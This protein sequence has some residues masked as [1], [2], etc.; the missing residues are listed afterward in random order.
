MTDD[1]FRTPGKD[2]AIF[3]GLACGL[4]W[5]LDIPMARAL[6]NGARPS[7]ATMAMA[8][9]SA[10]GPTLAA[11]LVAGFRKELRSVFG[12][13]RTHPR[14]IVLSLLLL[15]ALHLVATLTELALGGSPAQWFYPPEKAEHVLA[16]VFF[17]VGEEFGWRGFAHPRLAQR[18]GVVP[19]SVIIGLVWTA[20][21]YVMWFTPAGAPSAADLAQGVV[22]LVAG[23]LIYAWVFER[24]GR[25]MAVAIAL[26][27]SAHLDNTFRAPDSEFR[28]RMLRLVVLSAVAGLATWSLLKRDR[29]RA[30]PAPM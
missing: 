22:Q 26:H 12:H 17:S 9:L 27:M 7:E 1:T 29:A 5:L 3:F 8:G 16:L 15:P 6:L 24:A 11:L 13:W 19:G 14:W 2:T 25:S 4:T 21:H 20:W 30:V 10:L 23:S 28:L 18:L